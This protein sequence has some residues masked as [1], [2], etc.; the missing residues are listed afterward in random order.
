MVCTGS[1]A[2]TLAD[3]R[4][5]RI[6]SAP[7]PAN[8]AAARGVLAH[9]GLQEVRDDTLTE[10]PMGVH[11]GALAAGTGDAACTLEPVASLAARQGTARLLEA[12]V[13]ATHILGREDAEACAA[14]A[15]AS[16][17]FL[18]DGP[19]IAHRFP[20]SHAAIALIRANDGVPRLLAEHMNTPATSRR[21][22]RCGPSTWPGT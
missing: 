13:I 21:R 19:E 10:Q 22:R 17:A 16:A 5:A 12:K 1:T 20:A 14:G 6:L 18:G 2:R 3:L 11:V 9:V 15:A 4:G 8:I 7:G